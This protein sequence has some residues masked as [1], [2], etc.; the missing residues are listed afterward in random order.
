MGTMIEI[1]WPDDE[2]DEGMERYW[3]V[4]VI[5]FDKETRMFSVSC[6]IKGQEFDSDAD[7]RKA[8]WRPPYYA[9]AATD[10]DAV[11]G[12]KNAIT[13]QQSPGPQHSAQ[14]IHA[15]MYSYT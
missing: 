2:D 3:P 1:M 10:Q 5:A 6:E 7:L 15:L 13:K 8:D 4:K 14:Y 11:P 9:A 12:F